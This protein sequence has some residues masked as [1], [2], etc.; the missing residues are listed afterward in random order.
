MLMD[1]HGSPDDAGIA[2]IGM[3]GR[4]PGAPDIPAFWRNISTG[5]ESFTRFS[6]E[7]LLEAGVS[8]ATFQQPNYVRSRP[9]LDDVRGFDAGFFGYNP[10]EAALADPQQRIFL[11]CVWE[12]LES[13][14]YAAPEGRGSVGVFAGMNISGYLLTRLMAFEMGV[15]TSALMIGNDKDSLAT[16]VSFRLDLNGP[17]LSVQTFC[18]TSLVAVH[19]ASESL[20][21]G[22]CDMALAGGVSVR[23]PDRV[24]YLWE[25]GGQESPDGHV[26]TFDAEGRGSMFGDGAAVVALKRLKDAIA[27]RDTV[28][29]VI[30]ASAV[31][32]DGAIKFSY[33]APSIDGQRRCVSSALARAGVDPADISYVE[34]H[35][36]ATEVGDPM[37]VAA[38]T[39]AFGPTERKQ[40]CVLGSIKPNV[41]HLDRASGVTGLIKVVQS[42]R[43][44]LIPG[45]LHYRSPNPEIDFESSPFRVTAEPTPWPRSADRPRIAGISSLGMG[46]TNAH[47]IVTEAPI[48]E[49]RGP[50][51]RRWQ[52]L[53]VSA[54]SQAAAEQSC[55]RLAEHL[56]G[57]S[58]DLGD[59]AYTL[60]AGRKVFGHR[61]I[62]VA[63]T[64]QAAAAKLADPAGP[65]G[66][67]DSTVGRKVGF[68][69]AGVGEQYPGMVAELYAEEPG[70]RADVDECLSVLGLTEAGQL[71]DVFVPAQKAADGA[72]DLARLLGRATE[73][74]AP[75]STT[76]AHL[77]QPAVFVAEY[78]LARQ[79][80]R[81][82]L[83]PEI[84]IGYSLGEYVAAC[85]AGVLSLPDALRLVAYR[86]KLI[87][88]QP[89]GAMLAVSADEQRLSAVLGEVFAR[90]LD[91]A[92]RTGSQV[93]LAGPAEAVERAA[94]LLLKAKI[95]HR[96]LETTHAFHSRMLAPVAGELTAWIADNITLN[97]PKLPYLSNV[98]GEVAT[99]E[100]VTDPGYWARHMCETV[101]FG[102][103]LGH[104]LGQADL[105]LVEIGPGQSLGALTRGHPACDRAQWPLIVTTLPAA[106]DPQDA[107][108]ALATAVG[109]LWL[110]GAPVDWA[111]LHEDRA[112]RPGRV[113]LPTY[114]FE[115]QDYWLEIDRTAMSGGAAA[116]DESDPTSIAKA[117]PRLP[118]TRWIHTPVWRQTTPRPAQAEQA[119]R[120]LVY[121]DDG[122]AGTLAAPLLAHLA[123]TG[124]EVVLVRPGDGFSSDPD[125]FRI[126]PGSP[127]DTL[128]ALRELTG[129]GWEPEHVVHLWSAG[130]G[131]IE[132]SLQRGLHALVGFARAAGDLGLPGWTLDIVT[133]G[134]QRVL[135][136]DRVRAALGTLLGPAR[137]IPVEY[138][139]VRTRLID[140]DGDSAR[141]LLTELRAEPADQ[142]VGLRGG[143]RWIPDYE[144]L[145]AAVIEAAPPAAEVRRGGTYLVTGGLGGIGLAMAERL[146]E[147]YQ[148][149]LVLLGRTPVP[150]REQWA[151]ILASDTAAP[152]VRR[153][154]E[155]LRRLEA[156]GV[157]VAT[158][159][160]DVSKPEDA[161]RAVDTAI[162]R[163]GELNGV[164]HCAGVPAVGLMQFKTIADMDRVLAPKVMGTLALAE[165][166]RGRP[167]DFVALF[168]STTS[169]T[170]GGAGQVDYCAANA[171]LDAF[172]L[173]D[174]LPGVTV[175][176]IDWCEWTWNGWTEGLEN[177]DEGS[178][179]YF[180]WYR[181]NF[182]LTFDQGWETLLRA[183]ASGERHVVASTQDF[184]PLVAMSRKSSI[185]SHQATVKKI[186]DAFGRHPRPDLSTAYVEAQSPAEQ[187]IA[188]VWADALG[189]EQVG[190]HDNFF[191]L[192]GNSLLGMEIIAEVRKALELSYLPPHILYQAPTIASLAEAARADQDAGEQPSQARDQQR[193]R[194]A[195]RRNMLRSGRTS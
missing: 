36:T 20:R 57:S 23:I 188:G 135:P 79:L 48:P 137:L 66:R 179:Q 121:T 106:N 37:E 122:L 16:N 174:E 123:E 86:A 97:A 33:L 187:A 156:A 43:N 143:Q 73:P 61:R 19:L 7:E 77:I 115:H 93:V 105:A 133:S 117:Y 173:G 104:V 159:A 63:D 103:G 53:P 56:A 18:S 154:L 2:V 62:V 158:V 162:E 146:A 186:R 129:R 190:V 141:A 126:R 101:E 110:T 89:E 160:G 155:G 134:G 116:F 21:R 183:L 100:V 55:A 72:G 114:P 81:W 70:F 27:D 172:A 168:S 139:R 64:A 177:Y 51:S 170:G 83:T 15:D 184:A 14:G 185:E 65:L 107:G 152:E 41:G 109:R 120:W 136:G 22:E 26:R 96:R 49:P 157:E 132:Q 151:S 40:Y 195:Q 125:G 69:I 92:V 58:E 99:A 28:H 46:G 34:A 38:L 5:V 80:V 10:R 128:A 25:E 59:V 67:A 180:A 192:G 32:N 167:V 127:E 24:G 82:G 147:H 30:R 142:V 29:A 12:V 148:A 85:L 144:V 118:D 161:R 44:E 87:T 175:T 84:M 13:A 91:V 6:D 111:A 88:S 102:R 112:W 1:Q 169:A 31:N 11:E 50:R 39:R 3:A 182:G 189:L 164:L 8:P 140:V 119:T 54:R 68:L 52:I 17:S 178:K 75:R 150:P 71:S 35:G 193:S 9:V 163:F 176:S 165:A 90:D 191:E 94:A 74:E 181:E 194:I 145:D 171:F 98:T 153:R 149:R 113:P 60:Q 124:K 138:P 130:D 47:A 166:L 108:A 78:A 42:L 45:T 4:F 131:P 95:G 76:D